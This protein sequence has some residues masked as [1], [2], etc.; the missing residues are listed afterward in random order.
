[1]IVE[2]K[3]RAFVDNEHKTSLDEPQHIPTLDF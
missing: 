3:D 2:V 1:M